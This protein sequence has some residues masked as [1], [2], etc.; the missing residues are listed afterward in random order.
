MEQMVGGAVEALY[1]HGEAFLKSG[2]G[3]RFKSLLLKRVLPLKRVNYLCSRI[4]MMSNETAIPDRI[5]E[6]LG[7]TYDISAND[8]ARAPSEGPLV[9][10]ANHPFG[11][12]EGIILASMLLKKRSD[13]KIMANFLLNGLGL[14][15][16]NELLI[17]VDPFERQGSVAHNLKPL[18]EAIEWVRGGRALGIFPAGEVSHMHLSSLSVVDRQWSRTVARIVKKSEATILPVYFEG[19]NSPLFCGLGLLHPLLRTL[20]LPAENMK[21]RHR[22]VR[23]HVGRPVP[24]KR[25]ADLDDSAIMDYLRLRTYNLRN[26]KCAKHRNLLF[27]RPINSSARLRPV[28]RAKESGL[29]AAEIRCLPPEQLLFSSK[30]FDV[31][32]ASAAQIP[33]ALHEIGR[34]REISFRKAGEGTGNAIDLDRFDEYYRHIMLWDRERCEIIGGYRLGCADAILR[35]RGLRGLYTSTLFE[36]K[37]EM[38]LKF[39]W[40]LELGRSFVRPEHQK[41]Y[42]P[43]MLLWSGIG[44]FI[45]K[46]PQYRFLFGAVSINS[47]YLGVSR[48]L[49][50]EFLKQGHT[51]SDLAR[52]VRAR[53]SPSFRAMWKKHLGLPYS[54]VNQVQDLSELISD[55]E[56]NGAGIPILLKHYMKLGGKFLGYSVDPKFNN[57]LDALVLVDLARTDLKILGRYMGQQGAVSFLHFNAVGPENAADCGLPGGKCA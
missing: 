16:L 26:R 27:R 13:I 34:L 52:F 4:N 49:M 35:E 10:V 29:I 39:S 31:V 44:R 50:V 37:D 36:Y 14:R 56:Q 42:Q 25:L 7:V 45:L 53:N 51:H 2:W 30:N 32:S 15:E 21:K 5:L 22:V 19:H 3:Q 8:Q 33:S 38:A 57:A 9:V 12:I 28:A 1:G 41:T 54:M 43:L 55:I 11:G 17:Y 40:A 18:R 24:F 23:V 46:H 47:E 20:M 48:K 6:V